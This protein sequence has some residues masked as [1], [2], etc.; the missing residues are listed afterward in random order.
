MIKRIRDK[1]RSLG[2]FRYFGLVAQSKVKIKTQSKCLRSTLEVSRD[3]LKV[4]TLDT[5]CQR[6]T[7]MLG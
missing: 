6:D 7:G 1:K 4:L 5:G 2:V 3:S